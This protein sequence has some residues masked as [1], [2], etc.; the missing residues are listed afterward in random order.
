[1]DI[2]FVWDDGTETY[3]V[4]EEEGQEEEWPEEEEGGDDNTVG[5]AACYT[6]WTVNCIYDWS[7][8]DDHTQHDTFSLPELI[9]TGQGEKTMATTA[10]DKCKHHEAEK[11]TDNKAQ[12]KENTEE[13]IINVL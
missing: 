4:Y 7:T 2:R 8:T 13:I 11:D 12:A 5:M 1:L 10:Q 6:N 9:T 3:W